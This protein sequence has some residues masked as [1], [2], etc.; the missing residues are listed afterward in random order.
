MERSIK[1]EI[2]H[3]SS[4]AIIFLVFHSHN[5]DVY[6]MSQFIR[7]KLFALFLDK[8]PLDYGQL[9]VCAIYCGMLS[10]C[11]LWS[12]L[13]YFLWLDMRY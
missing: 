7:S 2:I 10:L 4:L 8:A 5:V 3:C 9:E 1:G 6:G 13:T 11:R 12:R